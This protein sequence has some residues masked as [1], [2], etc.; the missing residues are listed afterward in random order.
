[1]LPHPKG[2][3]FCAVLLCMVFEGMHFISIPN[4]KERVICKFKVDF[5]KSFCWCSN[6]SNDNIMYAY[7]R[8]ENGSGK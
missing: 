8:S 2:Y 5:K 4:K 3:G 7:A 1:M 6:L